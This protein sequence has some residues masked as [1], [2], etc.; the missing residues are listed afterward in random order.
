MIDAHPLFEIMID[1]L[2]NQANG[3]RL[4]PRLGAYYSLSDPST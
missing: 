4:V 3:V 1:P 2:G